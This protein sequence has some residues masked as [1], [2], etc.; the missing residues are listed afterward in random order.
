MSSRATDPT[1]AEITALCLAIQAGWTPDERL[2]RLRVDWRPMVP[3]ADGRLLA[4]SADDYGAH[5]NPV[6]TVRAGE[7][8][9]DKGRR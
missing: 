1:P 4:V 8:F 3:T 7:R 5:E 2:R 6:R 9:F